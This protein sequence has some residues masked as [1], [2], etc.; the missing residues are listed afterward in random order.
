MFLGNSAIVSH[1]L[2]PASIAPGNVASVPRWQGS[3]RH[4]A[5]TVMCL[6]MCVCVGAMSFY[7]R[8]AP[9]GAVRM[10]SHLWSWSLEAVSKRFHRTAH[11]KHQPITLIMASC[12]GVKKWNGKSKM[13]TVD[14]L[15][16]NMPLSKLKTYLSELEA[17]KWSSARLLAREV[18]TA[19]LLQT[20]KPKLHPV[21]L[22]EYTSAAPAPGDEL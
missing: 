18:E 20:D 17:S 14:I 7:S 21:Q 2:G 19:I 3:A 9:A 1:P 10:P 22:R 16:M 11:H 15:A 12:C 8:L 5:G 6:R 13:E 4:S